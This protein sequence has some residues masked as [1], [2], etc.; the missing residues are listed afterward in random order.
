MLTKLNLTEVETK[1]RDKQSFVLN[2]VASWCP[3]CTE[4]QKPNLPQFAVRMA[5]IGLDVIDLLVQTE[6][7]VFLSSEHEQFVA[8]LGGHGFPR[9]VLFKSGISVDSD[10]VEIISSEQL[11]ELTEKFKAQL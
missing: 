5:D 9:T 8:G 6:K 11:Q 10:N 7:R 2:I 3:D 1:I 4:G